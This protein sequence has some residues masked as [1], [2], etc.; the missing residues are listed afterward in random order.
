MTGKS[1]ADVLK[2]EN[3]NNGKRYTVHLEYEILLLEGTKL[4]V[5]YSCNIESKDEEMIGQVSISL[6]NNSIPKEIVKNGVYV[7]EGII[8]V[9]NS[10]LESGYSV[11]DIAVL[12]ILP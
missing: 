9:L 4:P 10:D 1:K 3:I 7:D 6:K 11:D 8:E 5:G 12:N 2:E